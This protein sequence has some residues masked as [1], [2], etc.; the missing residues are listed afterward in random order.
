MRKLL[1]L[2]LL[3]ASTTLLNGQLLPVKQYSSRNGLN[4][5]VITDILQDE[6]GIL[7][8]STNNGLNWYDG[9]R[10]YHPEI[11]G[12]AGQININRL[13]KDSSGNVWI[14]TY[15]NGL[16]CY[17]NNSFENFLPETS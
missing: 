1:I 13:R 9:S 16:F 17:K 14:A 11:Q 4:S 10:F 2:I 7:W 6:R 8:V 3:L 15:Y 5:N 12:K